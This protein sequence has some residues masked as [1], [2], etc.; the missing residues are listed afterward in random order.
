LPA[1][2]PLQRQWCEVLWCC[3]ITLMRE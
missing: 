3:R 1:S 2:S